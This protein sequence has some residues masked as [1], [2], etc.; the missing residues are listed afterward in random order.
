MAHAD[1]HYG[2]LAGMAPRTNHQEPGDA[3][4]C[5]EN[6]EALKDRGQWHAKFAWED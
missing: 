6:F 3:I 5:Q 1:E 4:R 2:C